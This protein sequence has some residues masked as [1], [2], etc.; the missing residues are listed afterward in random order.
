MRNEN[1]VLLMETLTSLVNVMRERLLT[2][3]F[4]QE[5]KKAYLADVIKREKKTN[6]TKEKLEVKYSAAV[7]GKEVEVN[8]P[9]INSKTLKP[10]LSINCCLMLRII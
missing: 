2:S 10:P 3:P 7:K 5:G 9:S 4:E 1:H 8:N 6:A